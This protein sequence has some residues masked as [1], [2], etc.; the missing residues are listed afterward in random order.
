MKMA[1]LIGAFLRDLHVTLPALE[2]KALPC[3]SASQFAV[4]LKS[5]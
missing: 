4:V 1:H 3:H 2:D 5:T